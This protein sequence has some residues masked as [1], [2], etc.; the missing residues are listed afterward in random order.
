MTLPEAPFAE[1][2]SPAQPFPVPTEALQHR[3]IGLLRGVYKPFST[4]EEAKDSEK[5]SEKSVDDEDEKITQGTLTTTDYVIIDAVLLGRVISLVRNHLDLSK[6]YLWVVYPRTR[7]TGGLHAQIIGVWSPEG[8]LHMVDENAPS[9]EASAL[10]GFFSIR[11]EVVFYSREEQ[12]ALV[13]IR[14]QK[15]K[16]KLGKA[17]KLRIE[18]TIP[19]NARNKFWDFEVRREGEKLSLIKAK[20][21]AELPSKKFTG[22]SGQRPGP[23]RSKQPE[24]TWKKK[25]MP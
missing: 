7:E 6:E 4:E 17:F 9:T 1:R 23:P 22:R 2:T 25:P 24:R 20:F 18:G 5:S 12:Y 11:G 13:K 21:V 16:N 3:A 8:T 14:Q 19:E 15:K 10:D